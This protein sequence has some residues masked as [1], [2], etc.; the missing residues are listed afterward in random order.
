M[1]GQAGGLLLA[2]PSTN[3]Q[4]STLARAVYVVFGATGGIGSALVHRL[5]KQANAAV[6]MVGRCVLAAEECGLVW[7]GVSMAL[8]LRSADVQTHPRTQG[9]GKA[10]QAA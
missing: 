7:V 6:L 8:R 3:H 1:E 4:R 2:A 10:R 9:P 5:A